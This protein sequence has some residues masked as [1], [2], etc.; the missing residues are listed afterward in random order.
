[1]INYLTLLGLFWAPKTGAE[2]KSR[3]PLARRQAFAAGE[4]CRT[5]GLRRRARRKTAG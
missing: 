5:P 2:M 3:S 4:G 1:M